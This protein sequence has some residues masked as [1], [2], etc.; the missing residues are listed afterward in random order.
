[1]TAPEKVLPGS[2]KREYRRQPGT[3]YLCVV[4]GHQHA[5]WNEAASCQY[6]AVEVTGE[7]RHAVVHRHLLGPGEAVTS[8]TLHRGPDN[9]VIASKA[10]RACHRARRDGFIGYVVDLGRV[11]SGPNPSEPRT[12]SQQGDSR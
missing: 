12:R 4:C 8:L 2:A 6:P 9:A 7:G 11:A 1:V 3:G 10:C 5:T